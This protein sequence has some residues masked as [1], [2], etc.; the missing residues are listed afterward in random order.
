MLPMLIPQIWLWTIYPHMANLPTLPSAN[1]L[2][3]SPTNDFKEVLLP[4]S[5]TSH[6]PLVTK[7]A[8]QHDNMLCTPSAFNVPV[9]SLHQKSCLIALI[10]CQ[11]ECIYS[12]SPHYVTIANHNAPALPIAHHMPPPPTQKSTQYTKQ[13]FNPSLCESLDVTSGNTKW[14]HYKTKLLLLWTEFKL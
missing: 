4:D 9:P 10:T 6:M 11:R 5:D 8:Q 13:T 7:A 2:A 12:P 3:P 14:Q 1:T